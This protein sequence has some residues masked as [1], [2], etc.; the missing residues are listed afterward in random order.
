[1][2]THSP[3]GFER[4]RR[5]FLK[6]LGKGLLFLLLPKKGSS[7]GIGPELGFYRKKKA[8]FWKPLENGLIQCQL[9]PRT[10]IVEDGE[11]GFCRTRENHGGVYYTLTY[12]NPCAVHVDPIEKKPFFHVLPG[13]FAFS[14]ATSG[15]NLRCKFCQNWRISQVTVRDTYNYNLPP[16]LVVELARRA[17]VYTITSTYTEPTVFIEYGLEIAKNAKEIGLL[18]TEHSNGFINVKP[19]LKLCE[20][21]DAACIDLK[22]FSEE[23]YRSMS[24]AWLSPVLRT[25]ETLKSKGVWVEVVNLVIPTKND[26]TSM[27]RDM[28]KW[29]RDHLGPETPLHFSRFFPL[30]KLKNLPPT[31]I[32]TLEMA[33]E[34]AISEGLKFVYIG[35]VPGHERENTFCPSCGNLL[36]KRRGFWVEKND[37]RDGKCP[38]C[39]K[40]IPGIWST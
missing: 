16:S 32:S 4:T 15:C 39:G 2:D 18:Y 8:L 13:T 7:Q 36:I 30:Y 22:G 29:I 6:L 34:T 20:F 40:E 27:I 9:C 10:C 31:P 14:I 1:M 37:I 26:R 33:I 24:S 21:L 25:L 23:F 11:S 5:E 28:A 17:R 35:N 12:G 3:S 19:L 38:H